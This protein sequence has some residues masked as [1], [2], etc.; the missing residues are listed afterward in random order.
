MIVALV[1]A[2][3]ALIVLIVELVVLLVEL[4]IWGILWLVGR[5][6]ERPNLRQGH[7]RFQPKDLLP[8]LLAYGLVALG[9]GGFIAHEAF[10][11]ARVSFSSDSVIP[12]WA[13][14]YEL[15]SDSG[16]VQ[17]KT[18]ADDYLTYRWDYL[19]VTDERYEP[20]QVDLTGK[21]QVIAL[22]SRRLEKLTEELKEKA[23]GKVSGFLKGLRSKEDSPIE[24]QSEESSEEVEGE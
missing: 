8:K 17:S 19:V 15:R 21:D 5:K 3:I 22:K 11:K 12:T 13:V 6:K 18:R 23:A 24:E 20:V 1:E 10:L 14:Q 16:R 9:V 2:L 4:A 7:R